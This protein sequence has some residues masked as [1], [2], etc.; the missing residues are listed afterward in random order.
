MQDWLADIDSSNFGIMVEKEGRVC[1]RF[2]CY[3]L[4]QM[5]SMSALTNG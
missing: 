2:C 5:I 4:C 3:R 1:K